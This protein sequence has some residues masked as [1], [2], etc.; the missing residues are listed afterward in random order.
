MDIGVHAITTALSVE[1]PDEAQSQWSATILVP[2]ELGDCSLRGFSRIE[3]N[4]TSSARPTARLVLNLGLLN[5][6]DSGEQFNKILVARG[7]GKLP[8]VSV[9]F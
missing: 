9:G 3:T 2:L 8:S 5:L 4:H 1:V 7:P 6:S